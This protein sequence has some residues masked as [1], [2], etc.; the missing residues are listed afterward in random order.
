MLAGPYCSIVNEAGS[1]CSPR[2][3]RQH[4]RLQAPR[5][6]EELAQV[7]AFKWVSN[8]HAFVARFRAGPTTTAWWSLPTHVNIDDTCNAF[9]DPNEHTLNFFKAGDGCAEQRLLRRRLPRVR[10]RR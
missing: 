9:F 4:H 5:R 6:N 10:P 3:G 1:S 2:R 7:S 8:A